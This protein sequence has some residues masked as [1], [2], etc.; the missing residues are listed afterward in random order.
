MKGQ[1]DKEES[2]RETKMK[3]KILSSIMAGF[4][5]TV[6]GCAQPAEDIKLN[7]KPKGK[8]LIVYYSQ[9]ST[10]NTKTV[11]QWI[12]N[13]V[14]G[15]LFEITMLKPYSD[16]Y[17]TVLKESKKHIDG[18]IDPE[19]KPFQKKIAGYDLIFV[20]SPVWYGTFAP[21]LGTFLH[22]HDFTGK[23]VIPFCTHGGG[24]A[25]NLYRNI[26]RTLPKAKILPG[27]TMKGHNVVERAIGRGTADKSSPSE[28]IKWLNEIFK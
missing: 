21:P 15:E 5:M 12:Q 6:T 22:S 18:K 19:I 16:N 10:R 17:Y 3:M 11:A 20:G 26:E 1:Y 7:R 13:Q 28:V 24:G 25:G 23:T 14:G 9:S 8:I 27:L 4:M 2:R